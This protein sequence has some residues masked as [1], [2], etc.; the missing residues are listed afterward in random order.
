MMTE[1]QIEIANKILSFLGPHSDWKAEEDIERHLSGIAF[2][3]EIYRVAK[4]MVGE[5]LLERK[6]ESFKFH[7]LAAII[8][9]KELENIPRRFGYE[10][11]TKAVELLSMGKDFRYYLK[12]KVEKEVK[13]TEKEEMEREHRVLQ[14]EDLKEKLKV[15]NKAQ[16]QFWNEQKARNKQLT[17]I[18]IIS[19]LFSLVALLKVWG[20]L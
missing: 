4:F 2:T 18:A 11:T 17:L 16:L 3:N 8:G 15:M 20:I 13:Q 19:G 6:E 9:S 5:D 12:K 10:L 7:D 1:K 14:I